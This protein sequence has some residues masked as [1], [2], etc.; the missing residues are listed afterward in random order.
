MEKTLNILRRLP[1][2]FNEAEDLE[3]FGLNQDFIVQDDLLNLCLHVLERIADDLEQKRKNIILN[4]GF[5][6]IYSRIYEDNPYEPGTDEYKL[7]I[8]G[9]QGAIDYEVE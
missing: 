8:E 5:N 2:Y 9:E 1:T 7:F 6:N 4:E 3:T